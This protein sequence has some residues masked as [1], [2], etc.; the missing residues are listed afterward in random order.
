MGVQGFERR[1]ERLLE[2]TFTRTSRGGVQP[3]ELAARLRREMD[4]RRTL[5]TKG[6]IVPNDFEIA[7]SDPDADAFEAFLDVL[8][9]ELV[10]EARDHART[11][12]AQFLGPISVRLVRD[13]RLKPGR[14][15]VQAEIVAGA[16]GTAGSLVLAD[17]TRVTLGDDP[18]TLGRLSD[19][20]VQID[21]PQASR[22]HA[23]IRAVPDGH[24]LTDL[25]SLNGTSVN[26]RPTTEQ[27]LADGDVIT[28]GAVAIRYEAS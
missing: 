28:I 11:L 22:R 1:L 17:G 7:L 4:L 21:D 19:C 15:E 20:T 25:G 5:G 2:G 23:E 3:A 16:G 27:V 10:E 24:L 13:E 14:I 18:T 12:K 8:D 6:A 26:G 9:R